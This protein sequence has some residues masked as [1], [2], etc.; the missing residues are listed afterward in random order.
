MATPKRKRSTKRPKPNNRPKYAAD[1][2]DNELSP[3]EE[4][5]EADSILQERRIGRKLQYLIKWKGIDP[6]TG[7]EYLPSWEP[8]ENPTKDLVA[9]WQ[10]EKAKRDIA[11]ASGGTESNRSRRRQKKQSRPR[12]QPQP[13]PSHKSRVIE[14]SPESSIAPSQTHSSNV[15]SR[16]STPDCESAVPVVESSTVTTPIGAPTSATKRP[17]PAI[18]IGQRRGSFD[19]NEY[20]RYSQ[21]AASQL[22]PTESRTQGTDLESSQL[23]A[24]VPEYHSSGVVPDSQ[25]SAGEGSF[26]PATQQTTGTTQQ[27]STGN[28]PQEDVTEDSVRLQDSCAEI[29]AF[30]DGNLQGL[31]DIVRE[32]TSHAP[33]PARSIPET[34]CGTSAESQSQYR[35]AESQGRAEG[36]VTIEIIES[37]SPPVS[38]VTQHEQNQI[39][40]QSELQIVAH[41]TSR[42][43]DLQLSVSQDISE[44]SRTE[45]SVPDHAAQVPFHLQHLLHD[46][47]HHTQPPL[48]LPIR[49]ESEA[50]ILT[51]TWTADP[52][53]LE[54]TRQQEA[55]PKET[56]AT[57]LVQAS[58]DNVPQHLQVADAPLVLSTQTEDGNSPN[59]FLEPQV[60][61]SQPPTIVQQTEVEVETVVQSTYTSHNIEETVQRRDF[62]FDSQL[63]RSIDQSTESHEQNAQVVHPNNDL[64]T[65]EDTAE[66]IRPSIEHTDITRRSS[67]GSRHDS[68]QET[69]ER[70][71]NSTEHSSSPIPQPPSHSVGSLGSNVPSRPS[72]PIPTSSL[73]NMASQDS[74]KEL[75]RQM[76]ERLAQRQAENPFTPSRRV[77]KSNTSLSN[78]TAT[79]AVAP[80]LV[81][82][83]RQLL[84]T[85]ASPSF[86]ATDGT[87]SPS[88]VPDRLPAPP[89]PTSLRTVALS[90]A[91]QMETEEA[92]KEAALALN[93]DRPVHVTNET[94]PVV[95]AIVRT[96]PTAPEVISSDVEELSDATDE[97]DNASLLNDDLQLAVEEHIVPL[98]IEGR[99]CD[100]YSA[101]I[102]QNKELLQA[103]M[104]DPNNYEPLARVQELLLYLRAIETHIDLVFQEAD[105]AFDEGMDSGTQ[106]EFAL[107]FGIENST[108]FRFLHALFHAMREQEK[109][110]VLLVDH[111]N[112]ALF[113]V[114]E[115]FCKAS[116]IQYNM[117]SKGRQ[118]IPTHVGGNLSVT[119][120]P[121]NM[122]PIIRPVDAIICLDG[123]Q[124]AIQIRQ[125]NWAANPA[126]EVVPIL[127]LVI[128]RTVGHIERYLSSSLGERERIHTIVASLAN[129]LDDLGKP[130]DEDMLRAP[131]A[132]EQ[133]AEWF[134]ANQADR[135]VWP[136]GSI[137]SVKEVIEYQTQMSQ[138]SAASPAP[139]RSK[140]PHDDEEFDPAKRMRF[141]PQPQVT[142]SSG[143]NENEIT[144]I[145]D[146]MP[147]TAMDDAATLRAQIARIEEAYERERAAR[148]TEVAHFREQEIMWAKQQTV[149]EDLTREYRLLL[150]K[151]QSVEE[152]LETNTKN[153]ETLRDR[154]ATRTAEMRTLTEQLDEQ[155][156][157]HLLSEDEKI[158]E[159]TK[160]RKDLALANADKDRAVKNEKAAEVTL[161]YMKEQ[162]RIAQN[163][164]TSSASAIADLE[165]KIAKLSH[166]ALGQPAKLKALHLDRQYESLTTQIRC[167]KAENGI[168]KKSLVTKEEE[169][170]RAK[171]S[172]SRMGVG[173]RAT[174]ATPQPSKVRSRAASPMGGRLSNLRNG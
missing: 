172:G 35:G 147:G 113:N 21:L 5:W 169:L 158:T 145:S 53:V 96:E 135:S 140:R 93:D 111:D 112:D 95:P 119:I 103:F 17:S 77:T 102:K 81:T 72:T 107:Q 27:S 48:G 161:E 142:P 137:G 87:R 99:Q 162:Y 104:K 4:L 84:R 83:N 38:E 160:L 90:H 146:S 19:P 110:I 116:S 24:A 67:P 75:K 55:V 20:E 37:S 86:T 156:K 28:E 70:R 115:T 126:L 85:G 57:S 155:R 59:Q 82:S 61:R 32:G 1:S 11:S 13:H 7:E 166:A 120:F 127:H 97:D 125:K 54:Q 136:L 157:T 25:S 106:I 174:S 108:K 139:E 64:S 148:K 74:G 39:R 141:T 173:T 149:H 47:S 45:H 66:S 94:A 109:H 23:F 130:I 6:H 122:S 43:S 3:S 133:V 71:L 165:A 29:G 34:V 2:S 22:L 63:L 100:A 92:H 80:S 124:D 30:A 58:S 12:S 26:V 62:A 89:A 129:M 14:S 143:I 49:G 78:P 170:V 56:S 79:P 65:Q 9:T 128:S 98:F 131:V 167:L 10:Q 44:A 171:L 52:D 164:A 150:G 123:V 159:I 114:L 144:R 101:H 163:A 40:Q 121:S 168:L 41:E 42:S 46:P 118:A 105:L 33:S 76:Q 117:P 132:A 154:L 18:Q 68:S 31:L 153:N 16:P 151:Q 69:P 60:I 15:P 8:E 88:T 138:T 73:S 134:E 152:K 91:S 50:P 51:D 36:P